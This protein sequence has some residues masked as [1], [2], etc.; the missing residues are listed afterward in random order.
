M[1]LTIAVKYPLNIELHETGDGFV[2]R[3][4]CSS[5]VAD[6]VGLRKLVDQY[7]AIFCDIIRC[8]DD[9]WSV[10]IPEIPMDSSPTNN[11]V[12]SEGA[13]DDSEA[14]DDRLRAVRDLLS[15]ATKVPA[16]KILPGTHLAALGIDSI[17]AVQIVAKARRVGLRLTAADIVRSRTVDDLL[18]KIEQSGSSTV[19]GIIKTASADVPRARWSTV[20]PSRVRE[21]VERVTN[22]SPGMEWMI[23]MWQRSRGSRFQHVF[24]FRVASDIDS[25]RL[26]DAWHKLI[27]RHAILRSSFAYDY[28]LAAPLVVIYKAETLTLP[29]TEEVLPASDDDLATVR[30]RM[31][32]LVSHPPSTDRPLTR[33]IFLQ[34]LRE[35]YLLIHLHHFQYDAWSLPL[36]VDDLLHIYAGEPP[37]SSNDLDSFL[38]A[39]TT[40]ADA[41]QEQAKYWKTTFTDSPP[42]PLFPSLCKQPTSSVRSVCTDYSTISGAIEL[43][44]RARDLH[45]S[46]QSVF[47]A[48]WAQVHGNHAASDNVSFSLWH[49]GRTGNVKDIERLAV[50][51]AN[52]LPFAVSGARRNDT[53]DLARQIQ[54]DLQARSAVVEQSRLIKIHEWVGI[55]GSPLSNVFVNIV[56]IAPD[57]DGTTGAVLDSLEVYDS[58]RNVVSNTDIR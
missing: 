56:K 44:K 18:R 3:A 57:I 17:T 54:D 11:V 31:K 39:V 35:R 38:V 53:I 10:G 41:E 5:D 34:S 40:R 43:D 9:P 19:N 52:V 55:G 6:A 58:P 15:S 4:A 32:T 22:A 2:V 27:R 7:T 46:L 13:Q 48:S 36:L 37:K 33:A 16:F 28:D 51:C 30:D 45:I 25:A 8:S 23:G 50:P 21:L 42:P 24:G 47:L 29:W 20:L 14:M 12:M 1:I 49:S 26:R